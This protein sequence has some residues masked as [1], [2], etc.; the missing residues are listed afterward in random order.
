MFNKKL[1]LI[2]YLS[3]CLG[4]LIKEDKKRIKMTKILSKK[5]FSMKRYEYFKL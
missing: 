5:D 4:D 1:I 2:D 3:L